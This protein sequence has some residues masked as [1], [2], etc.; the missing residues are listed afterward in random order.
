MQ[1]SR[2]LGQRCRDLE[3]FKA[4]R[5]L[6]QHMHAEHCRELKRVAHLNQGPL[7]A[8]TCATFSSCLEITH[9]C[10]GQRLQLSERLKRLQN[11]NTLPQRLGREHQMQWNQ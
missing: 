8:K 1:A 5:D 10:N 4:D 2:A 3:K 9:A 7:H 6:K 11:N